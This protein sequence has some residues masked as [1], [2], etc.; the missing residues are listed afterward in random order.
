MQTDSTARFLSALLDLIDD[1][2]F[3]IQN[4]I[5]RYPAYPERLV[6]GRKIPGGATHQA[7][8]LHLQNVSRARR[9]QPIQRLVGTNRA[10]PTVS[11]A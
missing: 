11:P 9:S 4:Q 5:D 10:P 8:P 6:H 2:V 1:F 3:G 7:R